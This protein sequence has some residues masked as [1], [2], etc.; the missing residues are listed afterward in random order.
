MLTGSYFYD[1]PNLIDPCKDLAYIDPVVGVK[2]AFGDHRGPSYKASEVAQLA[3]KL[4]V[5]SLVS[6]KPCLFIVHTGYYDYGIELLNE[7]V[8]EYK[9]NPSCFVPTHINSTRRE[10]FN[11]EYMG[12][13]GVV[14]AT[15]SVIDKSKI[16]GDRINAAATMKLALD[17]GLLDNFTMS[18]DAGGSLPKWNEDRTKIVGMGVGKANSLLFELNLAVNKFGIKLEDALKALTVNPSR[19]MGLSHKKGLIKPGYD[20]DMLILNKEMN[21]IDYTIANGKVMMKEG[22]VL[23]LGQF[24]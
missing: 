9:I 7:I 22:E 4:K 21:K 13:G 8:D 24:D 15:C 16:E 5:S 6:G 14:D 11:L 17:N 2:I 12:K 23:V 19:V 18:S 20:A 10:K 1:E 3:K